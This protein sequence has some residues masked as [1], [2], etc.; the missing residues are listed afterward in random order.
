MN[1]TIKAFHSACKDDESEFVIKNV[2]KI[3]KNEQEVTKSKS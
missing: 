3:P 2:S 1:Q